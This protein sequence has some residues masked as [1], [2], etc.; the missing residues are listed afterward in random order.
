MEQY[1]RT[2]LERDIAKLFP[3]LDTPKFRLFLQTLASLNGRVINYSEV[4]RS[5]GVSQPTARDYFQIAH[6]TFVWR[7]LP[8][9]EKNAL[10]RIV[11]H[12]KGYY[13]DSGLLN[14]MLRIKTRRDLLSHPDRGNMWESVVIEEVLRGLFCLG[15]SFDYYYY[16]TGAGA[17][18]DLMIEGSFGLIPIEIKQGQ[19]V[20]AKSLRNIKSFVEERGCSLG[21]VINNDE[22]VRLYSEKIVG[23]PF[24]ML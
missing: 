3:G 8:A 2:Y 5:I 18:I 6:G 24:A 19:S 4:A 15:A 21:I 20:E 10:K 23:I 11:K 22:R 17:E 7:Q 9:Y 16:R 12:P 14:H 1:F 13:R